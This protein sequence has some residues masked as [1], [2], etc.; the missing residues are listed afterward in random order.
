MSSNYTLA[1]FGEMKKN[2]S[3]MGKEAVFWFLAKA[4]IA[5]PGEM[6]WISSGSTPMTKC[7]LYQ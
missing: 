5:W 1:T 7:R 6:E 4:E 2:P 3:A